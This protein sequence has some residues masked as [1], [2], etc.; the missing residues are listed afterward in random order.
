MQEWERLARKYF[1]EDLPLEELRELEG[2]LLS[3]PD[4][5]REFAEL[6]LVD[7][8][9]CALRPLTEHA[10]AAKSQLKQDAQAAL[11]ARSSRR[12]SSAA[13]WGLAASVAALAAVG[14]LHLHTPSLPADSKI[15][16]SDSSIGGKST[17]SGRKRSAADWQSR[18][19]AYL[20]RTSNCVWTAPEISEGSGLAPGSRV[21]LASGMAELIFDNGARV[22]AQGPC[23][24]IVDDPQAFTLNVGD[25]SVQATFGFKVTTPSGIVLDLGTEFGV[26]V[27]NK[28]GSEVHV[29]KGEVAFQALNAEGNRHEKPLV[30]PADHACRYSV[31]GIALEEF[32][33]NEAKFDW[34]MQRLLDESDVP[35]LPV[36]HDLVLWLAADR[37]VEVDDQHRVERWR[38]LIIDSNDTPEDALQLEPEHRPLLMEDGINGHP[39][40]QFGGCGTFLLTPPL[41]T[42]NQQTAFVVCSLNAVEPDFQQIINYNGP[43]QRIVGPVPGFVKPAVFEIC[44]RDRDKDGR[45][46]VCGEVFSGFKKEGRQEV[47]K[48]AVEVVDRLSLNDSIIV[49]VR[50][51]LEREQMTLFLNGNERTSEVAT[52]PIAI[53]SRKIL[54]RHPILDSG[55]GNFHGDLGEVLLFNRAL[56]D[57]EVHQVSDYLG[58]RFGLPTGGAQN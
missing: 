18:V 6:L 45:F 22:T 34:R 29:F 30:L 36:R 57:D 31:D 19:A 42:T 9:L 20:G 46:A 35:P 52:L 43:P 3:D 2:A 27:D 7:E 32:E 37:F 44:L 26:S 12:L 39:A 24:L 17:S 1:E 15:A 38:D 55:R 54:G 51:D 28:G 49:C 14:V 50:Y 5:M 40:V 48:N 8:S 21:A 10:L 13:I 16:S 4:Q 41:N 11:E 33:A 56:S 23:D 25:V 47:V 53:T 58:K